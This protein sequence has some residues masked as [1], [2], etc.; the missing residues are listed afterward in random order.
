MRD[1]QIAHNEH[2]FF[3]RSNMYWLWTYLLVLIQNELRGI[4]DW[5]KNI[6]PCWFSGILLSYL[7]E[8]LWRHLQA[9]LLLNEPSWLLFIPL[10]SYLF[11][12]YARLSF[13][14]YF[15]PSFTMFIHA[16]V[17][18]ISLIKG[19]FFKLHVGKPQVP[20]AVNWNNDKYMDSFRKFDD[21]V[22]KIRL[23]RKCR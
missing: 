11:Q 7:V 21:T 12:G 3:R 19:N 22:I 2:F 14:I 5:L 8:H 18:W 20:H 23:Q 10:K 6:Y 13:Y 1:R 9:L 4:F 17:H 16:F 15:V